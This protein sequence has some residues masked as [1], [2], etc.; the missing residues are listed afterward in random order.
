MRARRTGD[1]SATASFVRQVAGLCI[2]HDVAWPDV[3]LALNLFED[4]RELHMRDAIHAATALNQGIDAI[5]SPD[6]AFDAIAGLDRIDPT[7]APAAL[8]D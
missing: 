6:R 5:V 7:D 8:S 4:H 1:R 2:I 3:R